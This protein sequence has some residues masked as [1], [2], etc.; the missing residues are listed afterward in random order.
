M[1]FLKIES[2]VDRAKVA[3]LSFKKTDPVEFARLK[4]SNWLSRRNETYRVVVAL[5]SGKSSLVKG[6]PK[7]RQIRLGPSKLLYASPD[8]VA[9]P[10]RKRKGK[11]LVQA[12]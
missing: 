10:D 6:N 2:A 3:F 11:W 5:R 9:A 8:A 4:R 1:Q 7:L 12:F